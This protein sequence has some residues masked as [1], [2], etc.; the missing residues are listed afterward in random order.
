[1]QDMSYQIKDI[2]TKEVITIDLDAS[3]TD[4][5]CVMAADEKFGGYVVI[6]EKGKPAGIITERDIVN[7]ITAQRHNQ[8]KTKA[9]EIMSTPLITIDPDEDLLKASSMMHK[10]NISKLVVIKNEILYGI[11]TAKDVVYQSRNY[12]GDLIKD[13][14]RWNSLTF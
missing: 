11:I 12:V 5:A 1:M 14:I 6:L 10:H 2:M 8:S 9:S 4:V 7:K 3:V 13:L